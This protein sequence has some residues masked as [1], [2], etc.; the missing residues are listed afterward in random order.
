[1]FFLLFSLFLFHF[2]IFLLFSLSSFARLFSNDDS[3]MIPIAVMQQNFLYL[4]LDKDSFIVYKNLSKMIRIVNE[5]DVLI[6]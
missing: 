6:I 3:T 1:M 5:L 2:L 4:F